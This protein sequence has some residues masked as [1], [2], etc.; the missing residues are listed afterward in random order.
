MITIEELEQKLFDLEEKYNVS[1]QELQDLSIHFEKSLR[2]TPPI[3]SIIFLA[4]EKPLNQD[5]MLC[6]G[7]ALSRAEYRELFEVIGT[8]WGE[9]DK[10]STFHI[11]DLRG[12]FPRFLDFKKGIDSSR[13]LGLI[14]EDSTKMPNLGFKLSDDGKHS[15]IIDPNGQHLHTMDRTG[16]HNHLTEKDYK[17]AL[18]VDGQGTVPGVDTIGPIEPNLL[19]SRPMKDSGTH[20]HKIDSNGEH[21][22][23]VKEVGHHTHLIG[24][25]DS[26]TRPMNHALVG[27]IRV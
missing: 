23:K 5:Y 3:G 16:N 18:K 15:H 19:S 24:G 17:H 1:R 13:K 8:T 25:G 7:R 26:E 22:H 2:Q 21:T 10:K 9:G 6:D 4:S 20:V 12:V 27:F 11:P 14:Q